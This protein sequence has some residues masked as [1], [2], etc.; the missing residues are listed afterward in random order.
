MLFKDTEFEGIAISFHE[1][2]QDISVFLEQVG[3][4]QFPETGQEIRVAYHDACHLAHA[5]KITREPRSIL[6]QIPNLELIPLHES[7]LC[8]GSAG[9]YNLEQP[10]IANQ[11]GERKAENIINT[12]A[13]ILSTGNIGCL[14]QIKNH[15]SKLNGSKGKPV[16]PVM[17]TI[18]VIDLAYRNQLLPR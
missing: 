17:H 16:M 12:G 6:K 2:V 8:C 7:D 9:S 14:V 11:L 3:L 4:T 13:D 1:K 15:L 5:Q 18:E 10:A